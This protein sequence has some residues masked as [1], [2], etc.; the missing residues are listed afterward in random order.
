MA[1]KHQTKHRILEDERV[2]GNPF[3]LFP[4]LTSPYPDRNP[5]VEVPRV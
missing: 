3:S 5:Y 2:L 1:P 4:K